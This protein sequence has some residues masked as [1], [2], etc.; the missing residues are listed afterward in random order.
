MTLEL[1]HVIRDY[2]KTIDAMLQRSSLKKFEEK[3][4]NTV[5]LCLSNLKF[6]LQ[7][8]ILMTSKFEVYD[9]KPVSSI[10]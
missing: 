5:K 4:D 2:K 9:I 10:T 6:S 7:N 3:S 8:T 1:L